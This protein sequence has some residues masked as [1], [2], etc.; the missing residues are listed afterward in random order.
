MILDGR[1]RYRACEAAGVEP[2]FVQLEWDGL[3]ADFVWARGERR[4]ET[5]GERVISAGRYTVAREGEARERQGGSGRFGS[6]QICT[7][8]GSDPA[9][10]TPVDYGRSREIAAEKFGV[11][12]RTVSHAV[13][14]L[15]DGTPELVQAVESGAVSVSAAAEVATVP[16]KE[17]AEILKLPEQQIL[18]AANRIKRE[19]K[20]VAAGEKE[21]L[22]GAGANEDRVQDRRSRR[23]GLRRARREYRS[24]GFQPRRTCFHWRGHRKAFGRK[25][26]KQSV[27]NKR[28]QGKFSHS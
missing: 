5:P 2:R 15:K 27:Q 23:A 25:A 8:V 18:A 11:S 1:N 14:V 21:I 13:K 6:V 10:E 22:Q 26:R 3:L 24:Q 28:G 19:R 16:V 7:E 12:E 17:Q 20:I 9:G 4:E